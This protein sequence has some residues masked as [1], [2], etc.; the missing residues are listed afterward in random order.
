[1]R[2]NSIPGDEREILNRRLTNQHSVERV[3]MVSWQSAGR[4]RMC[5]ENRQYIETHA[6][7][8]LVET[9]ER[10]LETPERLFDR[11]LPGGDSAD[12]HSVAR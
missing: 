10:K 1:M 7:H 4:D 11:D 6:L 3:I 2:N 9:I 8:D 5:R 12:Q